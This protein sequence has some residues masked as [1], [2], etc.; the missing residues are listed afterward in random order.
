[1][2]EDASGTV[3]PRWL[4]RL[5]EWRSGAGGAVNGKGDAWD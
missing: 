5:K 1:V 3:V 2:W 4:R